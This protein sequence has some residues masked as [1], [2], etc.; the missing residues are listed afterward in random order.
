LWQKILRESSFFLLLLRSDR[1]LAEQV[2][3]RG[4]PH[5]GAA[6]HYGR[7]E[8]KP[9][10]APPGLPPEYDRRE[11]LCCSADGCRKRVLPPSL[12]FFGRRLYLGPVFVLVSAMI[13]GITEKR[14]AALRDLVGV[15]KRT[16]E[17]WRAWWRKAFPHTNFW[18]AA[19]ARFALPVDPSYLPASL[20]E[21]FGQS[22]DWRRLIAVLK[23]LAPLNTGSNCPMEL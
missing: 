3:A 21:W 15:S 9:R 16:L 6:L 19:R 10:G 20:L 4:C 14:A 13:H 17:R 18:Q 7:Y 5:C 11:S 22:D 2:R 1:N 12:R 23:F 8:R